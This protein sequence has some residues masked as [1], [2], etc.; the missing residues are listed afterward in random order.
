MSEVLY[1][2]LKD[3]HGVTPSLAPQVLRKLSRRIVG[4]SLPEDTIFRLKEVLRISNP[5]RA[6]TEC[7]SAQ[8]V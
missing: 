6:V 5:D 2:K 7:V 8:T 3:S 4:G 1:Y